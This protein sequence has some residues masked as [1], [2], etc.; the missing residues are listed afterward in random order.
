MAQRAMGWLSVKLPSA[1]PHKPLLGAVRWTFDA[2]ERPQMLWQ[3]M[4][5]LMRTGQLLQHA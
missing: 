4:A 3:Q 5:V 1:L 2:P